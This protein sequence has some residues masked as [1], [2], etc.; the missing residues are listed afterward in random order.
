MARFVPIGESAHEAERQALR[1]LTESLPES[2]VVY[3]NAWLVER[4]GAV[5]EVDAVVAAPH[6]IYVVEIKSYRGSIHG[7]DNDW[8]IP[9]PTRSPLRLNRKTA[10][11]L[12]NMVRRRSFDAGRA[13][14]EGL[15]FLSHTDDVQVRGPASRDRLH[16]RET[17][18]AAIR[19]AQALFN[20]IPSAHQPPPVDEHTRSILDTI[21]T[22]ADPRM[23]PARR[24][25]EYELLSTSERTDTYVE[26]LARHAVTG[27]QRLL[28][29]YPV[30]QLASDAER[31]RQEDLWRWEAQ[32]LSKVGQNPFVLTADQP[33]LDEAGLCLPLEHF[34]GIS[35]GSWLERYGAEQASRASLVQRVKLW[36]R[37]VQAVAFAHR[38]GVVHRLLRPDCILVQDAPPPSGSSVPETP[39]APDAETPDVR[40]SGFDLA[41]Q[42]RAP[43]AGPSTILLSTVHDDRLAWGAPEVLRDFSQAEPRSDQFG[44]G[45][46]LGF[47]L[48]GEPLFDSTAEYVKRGGLVSRLR[49]KSPYVPRRLDE[50]VSKMLSFRP[51]DRFDTLD[52]AL[53]AV[54]EAAGAQTVAE[55]APAAGR[56]L[57]IMDLLPDTL[58]GTDYR[59]TQKLG[60]GGLSVVYAARH[61]VSGR[62][63]ALKIAMPDEGAE[64]ALQHEYEALMGLDHP[65]IVRAVDISNVVPDH[66]TLVLERLS[67]R[68]LSQWLLEHDDPTP[69]TLS[70]LAEDL[71]GAIVYLEER[72]LSHKDLKPDNIIV[73]DDGLTVIDFS[74]V[75]VCDD[76]LTCGTPLYRD[77]A[78]DRW[79]ASADRYAAALCLF[80]LFT[81]RHPFNGHAP[82]PGEEPLVYDDEFDAPALGDFFRRAL[83]PDRARRYPSAIALRGGFREALGS[84]S[85]AGRAEPTGTANGAAAL[86]TTGLDETTVAVLRRAGIYTQGDLVSTS[87]ERLRRIR[88]LGN[89]KRARVLAERQELI[90]R[91]VTAT[92]PSVDAPPLWR[93]LVGDKAPL[94]QLGLAPRLLRALEMAQLSTVGDVAGATRA[95][96][97]AVPSVSHAGIE[98]IVEAL[99]AFEQRRALDRGPTSLSSLWERATKPLDTAQVDV[100]RALLG[101][102]GPVISQKELAGQLGK[103]QA[104]VSRTWA[105]ALDAVDRDAL[106]DLDELAQVLLDNRGGVEKV[107]ALLAGLS[108]RWP[109]GEPLAA[110]ALVR[111]LARLNAT[112]VTFLEELDGVEGPLLVRTWFEPASLSRFIREAARLSA[113]WPPVAP[114]SARRSL[115]TLLPEYGMDPVA[116]AERLVAN[117]LLLPGGEMVQPPVDAHRAIEWMLHRSRLPLAIDALRNSV[118]EVFAGAVVWPDV[119][120][121]ADLVRQTHGFAV[122]GDEVV[123]TDGQGVESK[124]VVADP[125]PPELRR[126]AR[127]YEQVVA[128]VLA[129]AARSR[130]FRM[131]VAPPEDQGRIGRSLRHA[132]TGDVRTLS[133]EE[134]LLD[135]MESDFASY[136]RAERFPADRELLTEQ[137]EELL[138]ELLDEHGQP[139]TVRVVCD[140]AVWELC[141][142][143]H[144]VRRLY[145]ATLSG[146]H[147]LWVLVVPGVIRHR[148]PLFN[149]RA[150]VFHVEGATIPLDRA[151]EAA[152]VQGG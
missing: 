12:A 42:T 34:S 56:R 75:A 81:G 55:P 63:R 29:V 68:P 14:V 41:K 30:N 117:V 31:K 54:E 143:L 86:T 18:V 65:A 147:G 49:D 61:L 73:G 32:V 100:L 5:Y 85:G 110:T 67:G 97:G 106:G 43:G 115:Q 45:A 144:L 116:L 69:E 136:E 93:T 120:Q 152:A 17:V 96:L 48:T 131:V 134:L 99:S 112:R 21:L 76:D 123:A 137:C 109:V 126:A 51:E 47:I 149:E 71:L 16:T 119:S 94:P 146:S 39:G 102:G 3:G 38:Q 80:E 33:F 91:G 27:V 53:A 95:A 15:V 127:P 35:L 84:R 20:R 22:G 59:I 113:E 44:L 2:Y 145:D 111:L 7:N 138:A 92:G 133:F 46:L 148:Q 24:I 78:L 6:A 82:G 88:G 11:V 58:V 62:S 60:Q 57:D 66:K 114:D 135:R 37:V 28:R 104:V 52:A 50:A 79:S 4:T 118:E 105:T 19:D 132:F 128:D 89:K 101:A 151:L 142:A 107:D 36:R 124:R 129:E 139:G 125:L 9:Q 141:G 87:E 90:A 23:R 64:E 103:S 26:H 70:Q 140:V 108:D 130:G 72:G 150:P 74:L 83:H 77:P 10:Q 13:W 121:L 1:F 25:R 98:Q 8:Y 122:R 40:V